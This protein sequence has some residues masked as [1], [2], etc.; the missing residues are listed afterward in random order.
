MLEGFGR[1]LVDPMILLRPM[2]DREAIRSSEIEG[3]YA[4]PKELLLFELD[5]KDRGDDTR[6]VLNYRKAMQHAEKTD[7]PLCLRLIRQLHEI[8]M[9]GVRG[10]DKTPGEFRRIPVAIGQKGKFVPPPPGYLPDA[11]GSFETYL[12]LDKPKYHKLVDCFIAHYQF[13][14][15]HP[16]SDGNGRVGRLLLS[17][18]VQR[19]CGLTQPWMYLSEYF[20][21]NRESYYQGLF[22]ISTE[23][24]WKD[25]IEYCLTGVCEQADITIQRFERLLD[26]QQQFIERVQEMG[27]SARL[28]GIVEGI[29]ESPFVRVTSVRDRFGV[30]YN[31]AKSDI[32]KLVRAGI[33]AELPDQ[34]PKTYYAPE[35]FAIAYEGL[36]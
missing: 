14:T 28:V 10:E 18:M 6:E 13:E 31:A 5:S 16:F 32:D 35:I 27:G 4:N 23:G 21:R 33:L 8:L 25:W 30:S 20:E 1:K 34:Y 15:I 11:L 3:T 7:L 29:F 9:C 26:S 17:L 24:A 2:R 19:S 22:R 12:H 36:D